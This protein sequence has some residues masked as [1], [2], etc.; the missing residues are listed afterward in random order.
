MGSWEISSHNESPLRWRTCSFCSDESDTARRRERPELEHLGAA[1]VPWRPSASWKYSA[2]ARCEPQRLNR[3]SP[4]TSGGMQASAWIYGFPTPAHRQNRTPVCPVPDKSARCQSIR[5]V[6][7][8]VPAIR[9]GACPVG[10]SATSLGRLTLCTSAPIDT[11]TRAKPAAD[12]QR[13]GRIKWQEARSNLVVG[14][15]G[16]QPRP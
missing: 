7:A 13:S 1:G 4:L 15:L 14:G 12:K 8:S 16:P 2:E 10:A 3:Q 9:S 5:P 6:R 11:S